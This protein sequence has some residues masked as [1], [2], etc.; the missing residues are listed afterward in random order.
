MESRDPTKSSSS[1]AASVGQPPPRGLVR[2]VIL[3]SGCSLVLLGTVGLLGWLTGLRALNSIFPQNAPIAVYATVFFMAVGCIL[4]VY[5]NRIWSP[6]SFF[7]AMAASAVI[8]LI[9]FLG[10]ASYFTG[11]ELTL[12]SLIVPPGEL[13]GGLPMGHISPVGGALFALVA[14]T[15]WL[16]LRLRVSTLSRQAGAWIAVLIAFTGGTMTVGYLMGAPLLYGGNII[17]VSELSALG[18]LALGVGL[19]AAAGND[20]TP[21]RFFTG[22]SLRARL[23]RL[24]LPLSTGLAIVQAT[25]RQLIMDNAADP[26]PFAA[27]WTISFLLLNGSIVVYAARAVGRDFDL[28][29][30]ELRRTGQTLRETR[31]YLENLLGY[32]NAPIIVWDPDQRIT[33]FNRAFEAL[34]SRTAGEVV[35]SHL[36]LL[37]PPDERRAQAVQLVTRASVGEHLEVEEIPILRADGQVRTVLWNSANVY[38]DDGTTRVATIAQGQDITERKQAELEILKLNAELEQRVVQRTAQLE[39]TNKELEAFAY[40]ISHDLRAPLRG[41]DGWSQALWEDYAGQ[42]D[43]QARTYIDRVRSETQRMGRLI[44]DILQLS[45]LTRVEMRTEWVDLSAIAQTIAS[46]LQES[47]PERPVEFLIERGLTVQG[48]PRLL[49]IA[50]WNLL[51]NAFKFSEKTPHARI[52]FGHTESQGHQTFFVRDN[53][54]GFDMAFTKKLFGAFQRMHKASEFPGTGIGLATVQRI[55][56]RHGGRIWGEGAVNQGATFYFTI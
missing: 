21:L 47:A 20:L 38:A 1:Q 26:A 40:S 15:V 9:G 8:S 42:L 24:F 44:D 32:A 4:V 43:D 28:A 12:E 19:A 35:G 56:H 3:A 17:P 55:I 27:L 52:E 2:R 39:L 18:F 13:A 22:D 46:R 50:L 7:I 29:Q 25:A 54:A 53:G 51:D 41:I 45:R 6:L 23:L 37:F 14:P 30:L 33:R 49:E 16:V 5:A 36:E 31:D 48:D 10:V 11:V 34:T